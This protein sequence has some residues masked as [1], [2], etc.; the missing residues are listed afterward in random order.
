MSTRINAKERAFLPIVFIVLIVYLLAV[1]KV[2]IASYTIRQS[3]LDNVLRRNL[4][5]IIWVLNSCTKVTCPA[6]A[7]NLSLELV[8]SAIPVK[9]RIL[10]RN[11]ISIRN[12]A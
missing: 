6:C 7:L 10:W 9:V 11:I 12:S 3:V 4:R 2:I 5:R 8:I 1:D